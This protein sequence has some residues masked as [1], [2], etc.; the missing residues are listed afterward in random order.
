MKYSGSDQL[1]LK[2]DDIELISFYQWVNNNYSVHDFI[3]L[4]E[5]V[6]FDIEFL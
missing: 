6:N 2:T 4:K 5:K 3:F 1:T